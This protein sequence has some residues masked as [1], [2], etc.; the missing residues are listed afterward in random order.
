MSDNPF[1]S[2]SGD[3]PPRAPVAR[4]DWQHPAYQYEQPETS[5]YWVS[6]QEE[7]ARRIPRNLV[8]ACHTSAISA[9]VFVACLW[10]IREAMRSALGFLLLIFTGAVVVSILAYALIVS[11]AALV[12]AVPLAA[13]WWGERH[14][15]QGQSYGE[16]AAMAHLGVAWLVA[17]YYLVRGLL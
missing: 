10:S 12:V 16:R 2:P 3:P 4:L 17:G 1:A 14:E 9:W 8:A 11:V 13:I 15:R 5:P 7:K 6:P